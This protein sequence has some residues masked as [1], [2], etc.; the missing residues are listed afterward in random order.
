MDD[1]FS[2]GSSEELTY[3]VLA[4]T[5]ATKNTLQKDLEIAEEK[6]RIFEYRAPTDPNSIHSIGVLRQLIE[7]HKQ[8]ISA[9]ERA[10]TST[11]SENPL[12]KLNFW[13][14]EMRPRI[15]ELF[16]LVMG[17]VDGLAIAIGGHLVSSGSSALKEIIDFIDFIG[18]Y[19]ERANTPPQIKELEMQ[20][21]QNN[22]R[23]PPDNL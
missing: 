15:G 14:H 19:L 10:Q 4:F 8:L 2:Q 13:W 9:I 17:S 16:Q 12:A 20:R 23:L 5:E 18:Q 21:M 22:K 1:D 7:K 11:V 6:L 3:Y